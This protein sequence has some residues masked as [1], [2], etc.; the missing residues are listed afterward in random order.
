ME[1]EA[2]GVRLRGGFRFFYF[3]SDG[4]GVS[5]VLSSGFFHGSSMLHAGGRDDLLYLFS[6][7]VIAL[8]SQS[9]SRHDL[10]YRSEKWSSAQDATLTP[11]AS[12][13]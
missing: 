11:A 7:G 4:Y 12:S 3:C 13:P 8:L 9:R 5:H 6:C 1:V 2:G 10:E